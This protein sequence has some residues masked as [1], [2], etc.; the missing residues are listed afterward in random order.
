[1]YSQHQVQMTQIKEPTKKQVG[2]EKSVKFQE[3]DE[4]GRTDGQMYEQMNELPIA[5]VC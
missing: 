2:T 4:D 1:M 5:K 3:K